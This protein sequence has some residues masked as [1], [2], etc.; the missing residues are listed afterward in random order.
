MDVVI[1]YFVFFINITI[2]FICYVTY[3]LWGGKYET[4]PEELMNKY[5][6][7]VIY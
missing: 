2:I 7:I 6:G 4:D 3:Q 5:I 1:S